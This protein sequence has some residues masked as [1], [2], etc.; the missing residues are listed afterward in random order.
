[1]QL[2]KYCKATFASI[3]LLDNDVPLETTSKLLG[4]NSIRSTQI[5]AK[6]SLKKLSNN[7]ND[8]RAKLF[9]NDKF[10]KTGT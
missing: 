9:S 4:H 6:V 3:I 2:N 1:M 7:M 10:A 8:L 5:Y